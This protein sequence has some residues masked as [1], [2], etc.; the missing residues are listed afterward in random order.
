MNSGNKIRIIEA[1]DQLG[2]GGTELAL[3][4]F[5][6]NLDKSRFAITVAG[7][8]E[9]GVRE[10][11]LRHLGFE[12]IIANADAEI[13]RNLLQNADVL[14]WH[15]C[16][17]LAAD[18]FEPIRQAKPALVIQTN[19]FGLADESAYYD[20]VDLD[21][22]ISEMCLVRRAWGYNGNFD[23]MKHKCSVLYYPVDLDRLEK[24][25]PS[26]REVAACRKE[27]GLGHAPTVGRTG[28]SVDKIHPVS[29]HMMRRLIRWIPEVKFL[30][31]GYTEAMQ[32]LAAKLGIQDHFVWVEPTAD[33]KTLLTYYRSMD[34]Y[35]GTSIMGESF[36][37]SIAEAMT[38][39][40]PVVAVSTPHA[41]NAQIELVDNRKTG[42]VVE[43]YPRLV[44][45]A[46]QE[47]LLNDQRRQE[48]GEAGFR[49]VRTFSADLITRALE[50]IIL[51]KMGRVNQ[52]SIKNPTDDLL[53]ARWDR[54]MEAEYRRRLA[55]VYARPR[56]TDKLGLELRHFGARLKSK[57]SRTLGQAFPSRPRGVD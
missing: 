21:L 2:I 57:I 44:A 48:M 1:A 26:A 20:L 51:Q 5:C 24:N 27:L 10:E 39:R 19:V 6:R 18:V 49:K 30:L 35:L 31:V 52:G 55:D 47:L 7:F 29:F 45:L 40:L 3:E 17:I 15:G 28:R 54:Q 25:M 8:R 34:V 14:H 4:N 46:C 41:D 42:L 50:N 32:E 37:M 43:A 22:Y 23:R 12:V 11:I 33:L 38:C 53:P 16:G 9:G 36:G 56:C 13:W